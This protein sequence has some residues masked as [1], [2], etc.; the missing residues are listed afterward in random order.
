MVVL[1]SSFDAIFYHPG[2]FTEF[3]RCTTSSAKCKECTDKVDMIYWGLL[4]AWIKFSGE[5]VEYDPT[6]Q[7]YLQTKL[8]NQYC[9]SEISAQCTLIDFI[10][11]ERGL[12]DQLLA[13]VV[14]LE[15]KLLG[16]LLVF[17][18]M[19]KIHQKKTSIPSKWL[20]T[21]TGYPFIMYAWI[22]FT[23]QLKYSNCFSN[24]ILD[25]QLTRSKKKAFH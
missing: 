11:T 16:S 13:K 17:S 18:L 5:E 14:E 20:I 15:R 6:F 23:S 8:T 9:K 25:L 21:I 1:R 12:K 24:F 22:R 10:A 7:L 3:G 4:I 19:K 2:F